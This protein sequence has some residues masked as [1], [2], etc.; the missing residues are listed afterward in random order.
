MAITI[1]LDFGTH[2]TKICIENSDD[3]QSTTYEFWEWDNGSVFLP[4]I[5]QINKDHTLE[6]GTINLENCLHAIKR[7]KVLPPSAL[8]L[9]SKPIECNVTKPAYPQF[10]PEP[11]KIIKEG[12]SNREIPLSQLIK[13]KE[14]RIEIKKQIPI[15]NLEHSRWKR[16]CK[17]MAEEYLK[18]DSLWKE[19]VKR[20]LS[21]EKSKPHAPNYPPEPELTIKEEIEYLYISPT[22]EDI[23]T[24]KQW[25]NQCKSIKTNYD[26]EIRRINLQEKQYKKELLEWEENCIRERNIYNKKCELYKASQ[27][28][29][30]MIFRYFKQATFSTYNWNYELDPILLS[31]WY[32]AFIIFD[33]QKLYGNSFS[34]QMGIPTNKESFKKQ[35][36]LASAIL[37]SAIRLVEDVFENDKEK[38]LSTKY[39]DLI[40]LTPKLEF[41][42][43]LKYTYSILILPEAYA[44][45]RS[46]TKN[47]RIPGGM[48]FMLDVGGGTTDVSFF[49]IENKDKEPHLYYY[50]SIDKGLNFFLEYGLNRI[51][52]DFSKNREIKHI[53]NITF[54]KAFNEYNN[55]LKQNVNS[56][57]NWLYGDIASKR[58]DKHH[59]SNAI[60][61]RPIIYTGG[62]CYDKR[63]RF[64]LASFNDVMYIDKRI[65]NISNLK[66]KHIQ[67]TVYPILATAYGLSIAIVNDDINVS[68]KDELFAHLQGKAPISNYEYGLT[69]D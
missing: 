38:F 30:P 35:K 62:G 2:Q 23:D 64:S 28:P 41:S 7:K 9:P 26:L 18:R 8:T 17:K 49:L 45:L 6:Y 66:N 37:I 33:I 16:E 31:T 19:L 65:L 22:K 44:A 39:E 15:P 14:I 47:G 68:S 20:G 55:S 5:I 67:D 46:I 58:L 59:F 12:E 48:N 13:E 69:E 56:L 4:S 3:P 60:Q 25:L 50:N 57:I 61:N 43:D 36:E 53:D 63:L 27:Q 34:I 24:Y 42:E 29:L 21:S 40:Q 10:P 51:N 52:Y 54:S 32:L 1:G 11:V